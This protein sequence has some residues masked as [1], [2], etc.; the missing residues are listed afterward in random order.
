MALILYR[1]H[2]RKC[3][4]RHKENSHSN[5]FQERQRGWKHCDC[6]IQVSGTLG[7]RFRRRNTEKTT[8]EDALK[9]ATVLETADTW[10]DCVE[11]PPP[12]PA[13]AATPPDS[14]PPPRVTIA[15][16]IQVYLAHRRAMVAYSTFRKHRTFTTQLDRCVDFFGRLAASILLARSG[17]P[18]K[19]FTQSWPHN[20]RREIEDC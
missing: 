2:K 14:S 3:R 4:A 12:A 19:S 6:S 13:T 20:R 17:R 18:Q 10:D 15:D 11:P 8:W 1:R 7:G 16:V 5:E 9:C